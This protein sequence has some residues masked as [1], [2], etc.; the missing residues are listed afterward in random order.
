MLQG[1]SVL[2]KLPKV[3]ELRLAEFYKI[4]VQFCDCLRPFCD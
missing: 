2:L 4:L 3:D 1:F